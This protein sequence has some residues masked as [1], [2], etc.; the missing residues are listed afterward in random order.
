MKAVTGREMARIL[1]RNGWTLVGIRSSHYRYEKAGYAPIAVPVHAG[2]SLKTALQRRIMK[3]AAL[4]E[5]DL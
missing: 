3:A 4:T 2:Q 1:E 5:D